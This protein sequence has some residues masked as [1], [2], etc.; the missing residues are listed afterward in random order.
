MVIIFGIMAALHGCDSQQSPRIVEQRL[1]TESTSYSDAVQQQQF[2]QAL[3]DAGIQY[4]IH[5]GT[6]GKEYVEWKAADKDS[7]EKIQNSLFGAPLPQGRHIN[8]DVK[9]NEQ[10][11]SWLKANNIPYKTQLNE[12]K[13]FIVWEEVDSPKVAKWEYFPSYYWQMSTSSPTPTVK[14]DAPEAARNLLQR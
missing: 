12:G 9:T 8:F 5:V 6:D 14:R 7:V 1:V 10:F 4:E 3:K 13:E 11:K 2:K